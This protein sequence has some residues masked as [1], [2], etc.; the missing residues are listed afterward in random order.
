MAENFPKVMKNSPHIHPY[1]HNQCKITLRYTMVQPKKIKNLR[2]IFKSS[3]RKNHVTFK[4]QLLTS[5]DFS[6]TI[7]MKKNNKVTLLKLQKKTFRV[8]YYTLGKNIL[9]NCQFKPFKTLRKFF[10]RR[11]AL[12]EK[13]FLDV[14]KMIPVGN[15]EIEK[16]MKNNEKS[17]CV[18]K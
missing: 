2:R 18:V 14:T 9:Q 17:K 12:R 6:T 7:Q 5:V 16:G 13:N 3:Q 1:I 10:A 4:E 15:I 11:L 8:E